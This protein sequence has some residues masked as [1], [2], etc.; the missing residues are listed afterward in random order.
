[1]SRLS[2]DEKKEYLKR[3]S[4]LPN[5]LLAIAVLNVI[6]TKYIDA[7]IG[8]IIFIMF[9]YESKRSLN[10]IQEG[11]ETKALILKKSKFF[12]IIKL[13]VQTNINGK[14]YNSLVKG[15]LSVLEKFSENDL[16]T[17]FYNEKNPKKII[18]LEELVPNRFL[19]K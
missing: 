14:V 6:T 4:F 15:K 1:M 2:E 19:Q 13:K 5:V 18:T 9:K 7:S 17:V 3:T 12:N 16:I 8:F 10:I 11:L